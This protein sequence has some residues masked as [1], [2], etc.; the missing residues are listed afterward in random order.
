MQYFYTVYNFGRAGQTFDTLNKL[1]II[2]RTII[3]F[4]A[5]VSQARKYI[6]ILNT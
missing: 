3:T 6:Y 4:L 1:N 5:P 2:L